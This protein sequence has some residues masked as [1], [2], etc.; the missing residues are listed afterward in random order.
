MQYATRRWK[1]KKLSE[2]DFMQKK[3]KAG[4]SD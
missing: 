3:K 2:G 4:I 1:K